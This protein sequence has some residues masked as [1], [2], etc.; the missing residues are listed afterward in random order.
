MSTKPEIID[1]Y[2]E[3]G[4]TIKVLKGF[5]EITPRNST[6]SNRKPIRQGTKFADEH[7]NRLLREWC[8]KKLGR[9]KT[10]AEHSSYSMSW[11]EKRKNGAK[12]LNYAD[13]RSIVLPAMQSVEE[14]EKLHA[15][16]VKYAGKADE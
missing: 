15:L 5:K 14:A 11:F 12:I 9:I 13:Y 4:I 10:I 16:A 1:Q 8:A 7:Y 3:N 2:T 6:L